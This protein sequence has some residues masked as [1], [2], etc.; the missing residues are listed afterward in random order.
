MTSDDRTAG[1]P[2]RDLLLGVAAQIDQLATM[3]A[4]GPRGAGATAAGASSITDM[5]GEIA[6][7]LAELGDVLARLIAALIAILEAVATA[8]RS[9]PATG[10]DAVPHYQAIA[11]RILGPDGRG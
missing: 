3:F 6:S 11:V 8:L 7:L 9:T 5:T 4:P 2:V 1:D 10:A